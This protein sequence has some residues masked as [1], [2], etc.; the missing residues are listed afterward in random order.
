[1]NS[2]IN[3]YIEANIGSGKSTFLD[4]LQKRL[5]DKINIIKEPVDEWTT[6]TDEKGQDILVKYYNDMRRWSFTFQINSLASRL[7][8]FIS[9]QKTDRVNIIE[10]S[11]YSD[12]N[13]FAQLCFK[14]GT[15]DK[16]EL[17]QY[18][19]LFKLMNDN[20]SI[21]IKPDGFIYLRATSTVCHDRINVRSRDGE[22]NIPL[23]YLDNLHKIHESW[24][25][26]NKKHGI[27]VLVID[28]NKN[29]KND[30]DVQ[31]QYVE[32]I[33]NFID[34]INTKKE[35]CTTI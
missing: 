30:D 8:R 25:D 16:L 33:T 26:V 10:R 4:I 5:G 3:V 23:N 2:G 27:P 24:M 21:S 13:C 35:Q 34:K 19:Q 6:I 14:N 32:L 15:M 29:F 17:Y 18:E 1:M 28:A 9:Q 12:K 31:K 20:L 7:N 22:E 11:I